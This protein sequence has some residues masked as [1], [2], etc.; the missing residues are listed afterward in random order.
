MN[1]KGNRLTVKITLDEIGGGAGSGLDKHS[2]LP[3]IKS[4]KEE[5]KKNIQIM[6]CSANRKNCIKA[7][8][9]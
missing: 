7:R 6:Q 9:L 1:V 5:M 8:T 4:G 2:L 3:S